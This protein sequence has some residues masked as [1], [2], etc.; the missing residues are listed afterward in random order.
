MVECN[1]AKVEVAGSNPVS[2][3]K[4]FLVTISC[5][6]QLFLW[7]NLLKDERA[8]KPFA[9]PSTAFILRRLFKK[10]RMVGS[11]QFLEWSLPPMTGQKL[12]S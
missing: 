7:L 11:G 9:F 6:V 2:R 4:I 10:C 1:L 5:L 12:T 8:A 3:S